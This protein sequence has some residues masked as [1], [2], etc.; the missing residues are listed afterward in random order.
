MRRDNAQIDVDQAKETPSRR[1]GVPIDLEGEMRNAGAELIRQASILLE[2]HVTCFGT[3]EV[4]FQRFYYNESF[5]KFS[6]KEIAMGAIFTASKITEHPI[7][8][9]D[10]I[11][12]FLRIFDCREGKPV[13]VLEYF[14]E[15]FYRTRDQILIAEITLLT[16]L[17][18]DTFVE[19]PYRLTIYYLQILDLIND[20]IILQKVWSYVNDALCTRVSCIQSAPSIAI[21]CIFIAAREEKIKLPYAW[22][23]IFDVFLED[24]KYIAASINS[25]YIEEEE[26]KRRER[27]GHLTPIDLEELEKYLSEKR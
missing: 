10:I 24:V 13:K 1:S 4:L 2:L 11:T 15:F 17:G 22:W 23:E 27:E 8:I 21:G 26:R 12:I 9:R 20:K 18:F 16:S 3:A 5:R 19:L 7:K 6:V 25:F 14:D